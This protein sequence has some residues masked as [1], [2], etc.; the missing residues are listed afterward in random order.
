MSGR[1]TL[2]SVWSIMSILSSYRSGLSAFTDW[3]RLAGK[4]PGKS[5]GVFGN[6]SSDNDSVEASAI[7]LRL[8]ELIAQKPHRWPSSLP[9]G[10][11]GPDGERIGRGRARS[12]SFDGVSPYQSGDDPRW[13][14]WRATARSG[15]LQ[16]KRF[17]AQSHRAR[18]VVLNLDSSLFFA[19][20]NRLMAKTAALMAARLVFDAQVINEP[21]G[22]LCCGR[23]PIP[24]KRG[25]RQLWLLLGAIQQQYAE[26]AALARH[27]PNSKSA[28]N[29]DLLE[30]LETA[31]GLLGKGDEIC[32]VDELVQRDQEFAEWCKGAAARRHLSCYVVTDE[33]THGKICAGRFPARTQNTEQTAV[34]EIAT[35]DVERASNAL[36]AHQLE[37][38]N[39]MRT[40]GWQ[41]YFANDLLSVD[42]VVQ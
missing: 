26:C 22:L 10:L 19:T 37:L 17:A 21:V 3:R 16:V 24:A 5:G 15:Q 27:A 20:A 32:L 33:L 36:A 6:N 28:S 13:V 29:T 38:T 39:Q 18:V 40:L 12:L 14:D 9:A 11:R 34:C 1:K 41:V 4:P 35:R 8:E 31:Q 2:L 23:E 42:R 7:D 30:A 25:R